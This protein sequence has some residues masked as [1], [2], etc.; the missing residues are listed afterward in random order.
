M[1]KPGARPTAS[2]RTPDD[3]RRGE[4]E[5]YP[6]E[7][8][9]RGLPSIGPGR[10]AARRLRPEKREAQGAPH[11]KN[12]PPEGGRW[13]FRRRLLP[14]EAPARHAG[15]EHGHGAVDEVRHLGLRMEKNEKK[16][17]AQLTPN[18]L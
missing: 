10:A 2:R 13:R 16:K 1:I 4:G 14:L 15:V 17:S 9:R 18:S 5:V 7:S 11:K 8:R 6:L 12:Q 3:R